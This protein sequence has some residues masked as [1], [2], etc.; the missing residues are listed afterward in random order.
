MPRKKIKPNNL[1][2]EKRLCEQ[3]KSI[4]TKSLG[5]VYFEKMFSIFPLG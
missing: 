2:N 3:R 5:H 4:S 1:N